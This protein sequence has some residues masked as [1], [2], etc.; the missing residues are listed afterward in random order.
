MVAVRTSIAVPSNLTWTRIPSHQ[1]DHDG[2]VAG[3]PAPIRQLR[4]SNIGLV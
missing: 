4:H 3:N 1:N 2:H